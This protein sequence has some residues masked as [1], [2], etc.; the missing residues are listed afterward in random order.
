MSKN[1]GIGII[2]YGGFGEFIHKAW[3][4]MDNATVTALCDVDSSRAPKTGP[5]FYTDYKEIFADPNVDIVSIATPPSTHKELAIQAMR[6]GKHVLIEKPLALTEQ[7]GEIIKQVAEEAGRVATVNFV[8]RHNPIVELLHEITE[9]EV[10]GK[11]RR[12]DL[13]N[14]AMQDTVPEGHWFWNPDISGRI[15]LEHGVH[16]FDL[17]SWMIGTK[18]KDAFSLGVERKPGMEDKV[19]AAVKYENGVVGTY[20]HSFSRPRELET[21]T[22]HF[23]YDLGEIE[24]IGWIPLQLDI[25]GWTGNDGLDKLEELLGEDQVVVDPIESQKAHS[26]EFF[27]DVDYEVNTVVE[28]EEEK[29]EVYAQNLRSIMADLIRKIDDPSHKMRVTIDDALEAVRIAEKATLFAHPHD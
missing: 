18:A 10:F 29:L 13:K 2:G 22:F 9:S 28:L 12:V 11:L 16:F 4:M 15:L 17:A 1:K 24:M 6:S 14:Y 25:W 5:K 8:L 19:F 7:D 26:S 27:Y 3:D 23:A 21:T 20:W